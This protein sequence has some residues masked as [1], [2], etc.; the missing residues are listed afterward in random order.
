MTAADIVRIM[1][2]VAITQ[3]ICDL[4][5]NRIVYSKD[6]YRSTLSQLRRAQEKLDKAVLAAA[7]ATTASSNN[8]NANGNGNGKHNSSSQKL[9]P[10]GLE[11]QAKRIQRAQDDVGEA[12]ANVAKC[13]TG[14]GIWTSVVFFILYRVLNLEY[15]NKIIGILPFVP[16]K[17]LQRVSTRG[18]A[19]E[20]GFEWVISASSSTQDGG[21]SGGGIVRVT[22]LEQACS[23][24]LIY[25]LST[26]TIK[27]L[28][29]RAV[30]TPP[31]KGADKGI[32]SLFDDPKSQ[33][34]LQSVGVDTE[35]IN[36]MRNM[37]S[38]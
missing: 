18:L 29:N 6:K 12:R 1:S 22:H 2:T 26:L 35:E 3:A 27:K 17:L 24:F 31:P 7:A 15:Q 16:F 9:G 19:F 4:I 21:G 33:A 25:M 20:D 28:V 14:P 23:F 5:A 30:G 37:L 13:H 36:E 34:I 38:G 8:K 10:K 32:F 11:K